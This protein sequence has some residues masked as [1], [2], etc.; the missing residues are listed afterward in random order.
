[1]AIQLPRECKP[2][3]LSNHK[4]PDISGQLRRFVLP[5]CSSYTTETIGMRAD[6]WSYN[7]SAII[8]QS[9]PEVTS[10]AVKDQEGQPFTPE[11]PSKLPSF[12]FISSSSLIAP[13][14]N[15]SRKVNLTGA[16][17]DM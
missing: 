14:P 2:S 12:E 10:R 16:T 5:T 11:T 7:T 17:R 9:I 1:M 6:L 8:P 13:I 3:C 4:L 15:G